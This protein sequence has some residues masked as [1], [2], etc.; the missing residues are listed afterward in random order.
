MLEEIKIIQNINEVQKSEVV[1][2]YYQAFP[3]KFN[4]LWLFIKDEKKV[5][6]VLH[7][8][9]KFEDGI[10]A[11]LDGKVVGFVGLE[12]D[13]GF[14]T[15]LKLSAFL[16]AF[17]IVSAIWRYVAYGIYRLFHGKTGN[18]AVHIDPLVVD[19]KARGLGVGTTLLEVVFDYA[20]K[21]NKKKV[22]L[23]VVDTNLR[24][25]K[26]YERMGFQVVKIENTMFLTS[27]AGFQKVFHMEKTIS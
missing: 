13:M 16:K 6:V 14:Y 2:M 24:A 9:I 1:R 15:Q 20:K 12:T 23:E 10:Y 11:V 5:N 22:I 3:K 27:R 18:N 19:T 8:C 17:P 21:M 4:Y 26:L 25:K 7:D